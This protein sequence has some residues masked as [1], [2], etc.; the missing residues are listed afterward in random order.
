MA[1]VIREAP[2]GLMVRWING[3]DSSNIPKRRPVS[4]APNA[5][6]IPKALRPHEQ[7]RALLGLTHPLSQTKKTKNYKRRRS[8]VMMVNLMITTPMSMPK[9]ESMMAS[10]SRH[11]PVLG[12]EKERQATPRNDLTWNKKKQTYESET[13][14]SSHRETMRGASW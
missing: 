7:R 11:S 12:L 1:E 8:Q 5:T 10:Y 3:I 2:L 13:C 14:P 9:W 6:A 4:N